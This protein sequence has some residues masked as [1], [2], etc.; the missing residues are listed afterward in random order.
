MV[1]VE[2]TEERKKG[3]NIYARVWTNKGI[4]FLFF[5]YLQQ[6]KVE[7]LID[8]FF[9][10]IGSEIA[11]PLNDLFALSSIIDEEMNS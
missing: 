9:S 8:S 7:N 5:C 10:I 1:L 2:S 3:E 11:F 6:A 4:F